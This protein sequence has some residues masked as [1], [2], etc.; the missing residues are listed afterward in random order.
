MLIRSFD[1]AKE[2]SDNQLH[3]CGIIEYKRKIVLFAD[4]ASYKN[5]TL[6]AAKAVIINESVCKGTKEGNVTHVSVNNSVLIRYSVYFCD[7]VFEM[8]N[9]IKLSQFKVTSAYS[10]EW[11]SLFDQNNVMQYL[12]G[13][14]SQNLGILEYANNQ[15]YNEIICLMDTAVIPPL[16]YTEVHQYKISRDIFYMG[17]DSVDLYSGS[18]LIDNKTQVN[19]LDINLWDT[20]K[21]KTLGILDAIK[22]QANETFQHSSLFHYDFNRFIGENSIF[23]YDSDGKGKDSPGVNIREGDIPLKPFY[24]RPYIQ[25]NVTNAL[26]LF[27]QSCHD[28]ESQYGHIRVQCLPGKIGNKMRIKFKDYDGFPKEFIP[29]GSGTQSGNSSS[30]DSGYQIEREIDEAIDTYN[31][32]A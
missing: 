31:E 29:L 30:I 25:D 14:Y 24:T 17:G 4:P 28:I 13:R 22:N 19:I 12:T 23:I 7:V 26:I 11:Q 20:M 10:K 21:Y 18:E 8:P 32:T 15:L 27:E 1:T 9:N 16:Y 5:N 6:K 2:L 3:D